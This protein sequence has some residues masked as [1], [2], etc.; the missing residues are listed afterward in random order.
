MVS[1]MHG[2]ACKHFTIHFSSKTLILTHNFLPTNKVLHLS[3]LALSCLFHL[4][5]GLSH[6]HM[7][8]QVLRLLSQV[9]VL[10]A[11]YLPFPEHPI[12]CR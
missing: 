9:H 4:Q 11:T 12:P 2:F 1:H 7:I 3:T 5:N 8:V 6:Y 10:P